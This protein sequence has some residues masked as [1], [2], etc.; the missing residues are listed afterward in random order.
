MINPPPYF[1]DLD[2]TVDEYIKKHLYT[3]SK[4]WQDGFDVRGYFIW[5]LMDCFGWK[6]SYTPKHGIYAVDF[7]TQERTFRPVFSYLVDV[8]KR[9][10]EQ[11]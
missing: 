10:Q 5:T 3:L 8:Y 4:A 2:L 9:F 7:A 11:E 6:K 1:N